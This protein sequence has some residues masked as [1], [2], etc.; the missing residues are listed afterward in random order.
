MTK[1]TAF[2]K[3]LELNNKGI[4]TQVFWDR[5][6]TT[7]KKYWCISWIDTLGIERKTAQSNIVTAFLNQ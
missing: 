3:S 4:Y 1:Q 6:K 2:K 5:E 7:A